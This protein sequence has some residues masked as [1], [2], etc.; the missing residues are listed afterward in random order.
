M[1]LEARVKRRARRLAWR[2]LGQPASPDRPP[3]RLLSPADIGQMRRDQLEEACRAL[4]SP[5]YLGDRTALCRILGRYKIYVD[6]RDITILFILMG[7]GMA[8]GLGALAVAGLGTL[9]LCAMSAF[10]TTTS[11]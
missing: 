9:F 6:A 7:L 10:R 5:L 1:S 11:L 3:A 2:L 4:A 8:A